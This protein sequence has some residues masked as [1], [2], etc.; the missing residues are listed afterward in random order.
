MKNEPIMK[1][2][3]YLEYK[4][5]S[6][7]AKFIEC[8]CMIYQTHENDYL[9]NVIA[10][11]SELQIPFEKWD[12]QLIQ[13][14]LP[15]VDTK[16]FGPVKLTSNKEFGKNNGENVR[17]AIFF[18]TAGYINDPQ[19]SA[20]NLQRASE[21]KGAHYLFNN[22]VDKIM[23]DKKRTSGVVL[24][25]GE[26]IHAPIVVNVAGPHSM[27]INQLAG[28]EEEM[29]KSRSSTCETTKRV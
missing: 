26:K 1:Q 25:N 28:V 20:H 6:G 9:K 3:K 11:A 4:D 27:K 2:S 23:I 15:I 16:Q 13:S 17:G 7:L 24:K 12:P 14:K 22:S 29:N 5:E 8:G 19:L 10:R 21:K 18:P